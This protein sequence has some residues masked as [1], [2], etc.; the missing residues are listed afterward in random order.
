VS[1]LKHS[2]FKIISAHQAGAKVEVN[3]TKVAHKADFS[4]VELK[5]GY[6]YV[7]SR[8]IS[9]RT[10]DN[11]DTF[12]AEE[13]RKSYKTFIG[14][15]TFVN[16]NN[17]NHRRARGVIVDAVLHEDVNPDG[18]PDI[19]VEAYHEIDAITFPKLAQAVIAGE[20]ARTS[21]GCD[22]SWAMRPGTTVEPMRSLTSS[23]SYL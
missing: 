21:M 22:V 8:A 6:L 12:P 17:S 14:R 23:S 9:S 11:Y 2:A 7:R 18:T 20:V 15:P 13:I 19:W 3:F 1:I 10:N 4:H 5:P 16:H